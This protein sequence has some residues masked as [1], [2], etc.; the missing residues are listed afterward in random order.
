MDWPLISFVILARNRRDQVVNAINSVARQAYPNKEIVVVDNGSTDGTVD[1]IRSH[2]L[3]VK[4]V[5]L[6]ENLGV[7]AGK[8]RGITAASGEYLV[9]LDD[10]CVL[11]GENAAGSIVNN[12]LADA[13]CGAIALRIA[14][15]ETGDSW[16]YNPRN[17]ADL[18]CAYECA[19]FCAGGVAL[20]RRTLEEVGLF[21]EPYFL[22]HEDIDL[23]V[24]I[25]RSGWHIMRRGDIQVWHPAPR[26]DEPLNV[27]RQI[28]FKV[29]NSI[30][31]ALRVM[32]LSA[33]PSLILPGCLMALNVAVRERKLH[34]FVRAIVDSLRQVPTC[35][36]ERRA[37]PRS[38]TRRAR[39]L[40]L[41][42]W[43]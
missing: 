34:L 15:P 32:P 31:L 24:R 23:S 20:R 25:V 11:D 3:S 4:V 13:D 17:G 9:L 6:K 41:K 8:N 14:D 42:L 19:R 16:P 37:L 1:F 38:W 36:R 26:P 21:W 35:L 39:R 30:W 40:S 5:A 28:Y 43:G 29:R 7:A 10:D 12:L 22:C 18:P 2:Y 33:M 27:M